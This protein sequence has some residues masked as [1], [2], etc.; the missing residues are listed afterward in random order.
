MLIGL[1]GGV[2]LWWSQLY[3]NYVQ[4][5]LIKP[6]N[7]KGIVFSAT[8]ENVVGLHNARL[9]GGKKSTAI[10]PQGE[11]VSAKQSI[12]KKIK[13][14]EP[15]VQGIQRLLALNEIKTNNDIRVLNMS[16]LTFLAAVMPY[17]LER[18]PELPLW[19]HLGVGMFN[20]EASLFERRIQES[21][22]N[23]VLFEYMPGLNNFYPFRV[24]D[25]LRL[26]YQQIDS[27]PAPRSTEPGTIEVY[28]KKQ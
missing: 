6:G 26:Y 23:I 18:N 3:W 8:G 14:P 13:L 25:S 22:Y 12:L 16:E 9:G 10:I 17:S 2:I 11:W 28:V 27:F 15:T 4:R 19:Y 7:E 20:R 5:V 21:Y 24:R 1:L